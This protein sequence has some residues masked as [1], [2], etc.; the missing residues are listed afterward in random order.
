VLAVVAGVGSEDCGSADPLVELD[1]LGAGGLEAGA[2]VGC[3]VPDGAE[4]PAVLP[5]LLLGSLLDEGS[6]EEFGVVHPLSAASAR[7]ADATINNF[8]S[9]MNASF[10]SAPPSRVA[11]L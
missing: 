5:L 6:P 7:A 9:F 3:D 11:W 1:E 4:V 10:L 2:E 8:G